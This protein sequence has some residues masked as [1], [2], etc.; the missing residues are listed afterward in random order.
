MTFPHVT[1]VTAGLLVLMQM[2]LAFSV[3]A[4]RGKVDAALLRT[5]RR[6]GNLAENDGLFRPDTRN[7]LIWV[8]LASAG[9]ATS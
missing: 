9:R 6:H 5:A 8:G 1:A 7:A 4:G 3:S 2:T